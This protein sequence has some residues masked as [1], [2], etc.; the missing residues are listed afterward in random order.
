MATRDNNNGPPAHLRGY[1]PQVSGA[2]RGQEAASDREEESCAAFGFL[3]G[4]NAHAMAVEFRLR[5]GNSEWFAY[6][7]LVSWRLNPSAGL[8]LKFT[9]GDGVSLVLVSGSNLEAPVGEAKVNLTDR[10]LQRHRIL[11]IREMDED[12][13]RKARGGEPTIDRIDI[14]E[15]ETVEEQREWLQARAP[16]FIR[17][18]G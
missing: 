12:A 10:G 7:C 4:L 11:Y 5:D 17:K 13:L 8:L 14:A 1:I 16:A 15:F 2:A 9:T 3:R 18:Q 6:S